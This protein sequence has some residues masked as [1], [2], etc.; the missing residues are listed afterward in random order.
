MERT[1]HSVFF[2]W[3]KEFCK[4]YCCSWIGRDSWHALIK[5]STYHSWFL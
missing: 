2:W 4:N 5:L 1:L 3:W